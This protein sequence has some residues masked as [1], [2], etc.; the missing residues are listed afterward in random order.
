MFI[1]LDKEYEVKATLGTIKDIERTFGK[2][3][4]EVINSVATMTVEEQ[5]KLLFVGANK[6]NPELTREKFSELCENNL[7]IGDLMEYLE[8]Y[9]YALQY[10]GLSETEVQDRIQKKLE[11]NRELQASRASIGQK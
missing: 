5:I 10:P 3:F 7:G 8:K 4:F 2:S 9:F 1:K 6:A 11:R